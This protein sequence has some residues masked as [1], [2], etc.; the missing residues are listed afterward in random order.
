MLAL[1]EHKGDE[2]HGELAIGQARPAPMGLPVLVNGLGD[3]HLVHPGEQQRDAVHPLNRCLFHQVPPGVI[4]IPQESYAVLG[5]L[6]KITNLSEHGR[7]VSD[8]ARLTAF[9]ADWT[10]PLPWQDTGIRLPEIRVTDRTLPIDG[11]Q[12]L[13]ELACGCFVPRA[14]GYSHNFPRI[15]VKRQPEPLFV[16]FITNERPLIRAYAQ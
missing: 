5:G 15:A 4:A 7:K 14:D 11:R 12:R 10:V 1:L 2:Q 6:A 13:S 16:V 8:M 9:L 3:L